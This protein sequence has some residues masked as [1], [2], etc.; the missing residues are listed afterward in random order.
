MTSFLKIYGI[1][2]LYEIESYKIIVS[3]A[4]SFKILYCSVTFVNFHCN[5]ILFLF[6]DC[7]LLEFI[8]QKT[9]QFALYITEYLSLF[10][11]DYNSK[12]LIP[13]A[14][15]TTQC[16]RSSQT[17]MVYMFLHLEPRWNFITFATTKLW[18]KWHWLI[19]D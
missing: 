4:S 2:S 17:V 12:Y 3:C 8:Y 10:S 1:Y 7:N 6:M 5:L 11:K 15:F 9:C 13:W 19:L 18:E 16:W 14:L